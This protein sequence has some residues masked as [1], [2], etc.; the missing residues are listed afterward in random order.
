MARCRIPVLRRTRTDAGRN[1]A[2]RSLRSVPTATVVRR[3]GG[4]PRHHTPW[5][6]ACERRVTVLEPTRRRAALPDATGVAARADL[7]YL[8]DSDIPAPLA[9]FGLALVEIWFAVPTGLALGLAPLLV[10]ILTIAG[11]LSG[12]AVIG[13]GGHRLRTWLTRRRRG[14]MAARTGRTYGIWVRFGVPGWGLGSPLVVAPAMGT[15]IGL[16]LGAPRG[17][18]LAWMGAGVV[19]WTSILVLAGTIGLRLIR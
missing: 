7:A 10:W 6:S 13:V 1:A 18:L 16:L 8:E 5:R 19:V 12:V 2:T 3:V 11:S 15:A 14:W 4:S 17:R 9:V